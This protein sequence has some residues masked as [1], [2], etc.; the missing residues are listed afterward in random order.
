MKRIYIAG[1]YTAKTQEEIAANIDR[2]REA[3]IM[4][5]RA[6]FAPL[7]PHCNTAGWD[8]IVGLSYDVFLAID[9]AWMGAADAIYFQG[10]YM[11]SHGCAVE[12]RTAAAMG[13]PVFYEGIHTPEDIKKAL[14]KIG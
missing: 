5:A 14:E 4:F 2:A 8:C 13:I 12:M 6:G 1:P 3:G 11:N 9:L 10:D 7:I